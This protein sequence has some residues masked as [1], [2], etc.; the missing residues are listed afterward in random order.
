MVELENRLGFVAQ[1]SEAGAQAGHLLSTLVRDVDLI[2]VYFSEKQVHVYEGLVKLFLQHLQ[3]A[4]HGHAGAEAR[5]VA[6]RG[7]SSRGGHGY[8]KRRRLDASVSS[9]A[10]LGDDE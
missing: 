10:N 4:E 9:R 8:N 7:A 5:A 6:R 1:L 3:P 2:R